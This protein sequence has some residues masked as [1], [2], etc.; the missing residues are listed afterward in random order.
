[1]PEDTPTLYSRRWMT[2]STPDLA[3]A[4]DDLSPKLTRT[5]LDPLGGSDHRPVKLSINLHFKPPES[6]TV[7]RWNY[8][9]AN[10]EKYMGLTDKYTKS[11][12]EDSNIDR[13]NGKLNKAL[14]KAAAET[15]PRGARKNYK[16]YWTEELQALEDEVTSTRQ[17]AE[18]SPNEQN[19]ISLKAATA[20]YRR[21][22]RQAARNSWIKRT[23][24]LNLDRDGHK[25]WKLTKA[26]NNEDIRSPVIGLEHEQKLVSGKQAADILVDNYEQVSN[27]NVTK[28]RKAE[29]L[30]QM[31]TT[32]Q[33][34]GPPERGMNQPFLLEELENALKALTDTKAPGPDK[35]TPAMLTHLGDKAKC[36][37]LNIF[38]NSWKS[39]KIPQIWKKASMVPIYKKG[40]DKKQASSY[41]PISLTSSVGKLME[42][43]INARLTWYLERNQLICQEQAGFRPYYS[44]E[45]HV[46]YIAQYIEDGFQEKKHTL[47]VWVDLEKAFD[48]VWKDGLRLKLKQC[49]IQGNMYRWISGYLTNR[50]A[51]VQVNGKLSKE[52]SLKEGVPQ[53]GVL[54]PTLFLIYVND[55]IQNLPK[56]VKGAIYADDL[57]LWCTE[58]SLP[59]ANYRMQEALNSLQRWTKKWIVSINP[60]KTTH[61]VFS[62]ST[63]KLTAN[64]TIN[65]Q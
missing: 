26:L 63:K 6:K 33:K 12:K 1:M 50:K 60:T 34:E 30:S 28:Q 18:K 24:E 39:G 65:G 57:A 10:W 45:D 44:T 4:T 52:K 23:E 21:K 20:R 61:T 11:L 46:T 22:Y 3:F 17:I 40:K 55:I 53:G 7:P 19:N 56:H 64:L 32:T 47:A 62:L 9:K 42:R 37:L 16:P 29:V 59:T 51:R 41:R 35:V 38:N 14:L 31:Q 27:I 36:K 8:K 43:M 48:K 54:S 13:V 25:L 58:E 15:I 5:V 49:G 2:T